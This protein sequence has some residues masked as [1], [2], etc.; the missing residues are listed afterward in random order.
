VIEPPLNV[1]GFFIGAAMSLGNLSI[2]VSADIG[3]FTTNLDLA[4][5]A[6]QA[7]MSD[8]SAAVSDYRQEMA[9]AGQDT[10]LAAAK[11]SSSMKAANDSIMNGSVEAVN[12]IQNIADTADQTDFRPMGERIAEAIGTGIGVGI[13]GANKAWDGF[14]AYS[15]TKALVIGAAMTVAATAVGLGA[16]YAAYKVIS[17]SMDF[18]VGLITGDSYKNANIDALIEAND[19]VKAIQRSLGSTAQQAAAT[20]EALKALGVDKSDYLSVYTK[21][22]DAIRGNK[23]TLDQLGVSYGNVQELMQSANAVLNTYTEGWDR[24]QVAQQ[25]G[26]GTAAQ[27]AEAAKVTDGALS[28]AKATLDEYNLGISTESQ[29]AIKRFSDTTREFNHNLDLTSEGFKRAIADSIMP[30]L[31]DFAN[32]FKDGWPSIVNV[33]R[34]TLATLTSLFYG[35]KTSVNIALESI[36]GSVS[37]VAKSL[38]SIVS[39]TAK[40]ISGDFAGAKDDLV[41]GWESGSNRLDEIGKNIVA[42]AQNNAKAMRMAWALDDRHDLNSLQRGKSF[43]DPAVEKKIKDQADAYKKMADAITEKPAFNS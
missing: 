11:M 1:G 29:E 22:E 25:L 6:A 38:F 35:L 21:A 7:S 4:G 13:A 43:I 14:V 40:V 8:S 30:I 37:I 16:V 24:N 10:S 28:Q 23:E 18:I 5:K 3:Q 15:K 41:K 27:V 32:F 36:N 20:N 9:K 33:F 2:K 31:T 26:L 34:Y 19:Q 17:G 39:A 12:S 42:E